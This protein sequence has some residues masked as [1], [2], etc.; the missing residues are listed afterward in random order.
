MS[1]AKGSDDR[2]AFPQ[3][4]VRQECLT[5]ARYH[6]CH[7]EGALVLSAAREAMIAEHSLKGE[8]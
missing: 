2:G 7:P 3:F 1:A 8:E 5:Y 4:F 6:A